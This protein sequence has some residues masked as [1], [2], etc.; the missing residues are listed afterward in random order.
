MPSIWITDGSV[1]V[2]SDTLRLEATHPGLLGLP[3]RYE[4]FVD[5]EVPV[6]FVTVTGERR[7]VL[8]V[9]AEWCVSVPEGVRRVD[10]RTPVVLQGLIEGNWMNRLLGTR[11]WQPATL[12]NNLLAAGDGISTTLGGL[13]RDA[14]GKIRVEYRR[15]D[16]RT[17]V[18]TSTLADLRGHNVLGLVRDV[19]RVTDGFAPDWIDL[20]ALGKHAAVVNEPRRMLLS[21]L[22]FPDPRNVH[23]HRAKERL[24]QGALDEG[25]GV[26]P[27]EP[28][29]LTTT[30]AAGE[31]VGRGTL[32][33]ERA[34]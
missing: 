20:G 16:C 23:P 9:A 17:Q 2:F 7:D 5:P 1:P 31:V 18:Y 14:V 26:L 27:R 29:T 13:E 33:W 22:P 19:L 3:V 28:V 12:G 15:V 21:A 4:G 6:G 30:G 25:M 24:V 8:F 10:E 32:V 11:A 34:R